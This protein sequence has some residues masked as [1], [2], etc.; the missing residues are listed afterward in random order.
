[1][2]DTFQRRGHAFAG[3]GYKPDR[4]HLLGIA[5]RRDAARL[6]GSLPVPTVPGGLDAATVR[7]LGILD[8][9]GAPFCVSHG[10]AGAE[11]DCQQRNGLAVPRLAS[12]L[13]I[14]YLAHALEHDVAA[15]EGAFVSDGF[16]AVEE[17]GFPPEEVWPYS[18]ANPGPF[19]QKPPAEV[20]REAFDRKAPLDYGR[21]LTS[22]QRRVDDVMRAVAGGGQGG[23]PCPVVFGTNVTNAFCSN[24]LGPGAVVDVPKGDIAGGHCMR[25]IRFEFDAAVA[26]GVKFLVVNSWSSAWGDGG[27]FWMTPA[28]LM[29][30]STE[31]IWM[32]DFQG[33]QS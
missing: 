30:P 29:D 11:R 20:F 18:D 16:Q 8:Q 5:P 4:R 9:G 12:R 28:W 24:E 10:I 31:D 1:V 32:A 17:L 13:W 22:G 25:I 27:M 19:S 6:L 26:G 7:S 3:L 21:I 15:F 14:M 33:V 23:R 2:A